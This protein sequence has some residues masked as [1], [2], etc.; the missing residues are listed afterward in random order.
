[1]NKFLRTRQ[2]IDEATKIM[3]D[4]RYPTSGISAK[5]WEIF[6]VLPYMVDGNWLDMGSDGGVV[7]E[8]LVDRKI[9][10][11]KVGIDLA[12]PETIK[13]ESYVNGY[14]R[15]KGDLMDTK[16]PTGLFNFITCLSVLEHNVSP[17]KL[18]KEVS[19]LLADGGSLF[20]S[21]D[22]WTPR[23]DT[24]KTK[25]YS[26][27][28]RILD[29]EDVINLVEIFKQ[30]GLQITSDIDWTTQDAV[31]CDTYCSPVAGVAYS[32]CILH[33]IKNNS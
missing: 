6:Q 14:D 5:N 17:E 24:S 3:E 10:G 21:F 7:L 13:Q 9:T 33:F 32:F 23:P 8:N 4:N 25:L 30:H 28:W 26:L 31:I 20:L 12:Y 19:R 1:M 22:Y 11:F 2:E 29:K 18:A 16:L 15:I 27:D